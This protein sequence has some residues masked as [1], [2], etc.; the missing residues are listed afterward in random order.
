MNSFYRRVTRTVLYYYGTVLNPASCFE[1]TDSEFRAVD[2]EMF[3]IYRDATERIL[4]TEA[5]PYKPYR[6][7]LAVCSSD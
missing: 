2:M 3:V 7:N 4:L 6:L 5:S 1:A